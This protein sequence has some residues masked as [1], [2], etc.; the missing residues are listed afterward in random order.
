M[1]YHACK[2]DW[3]WSIM[4]EYPVRVIDGH[5]YHRADITGTDETGEV[6]RR[7]TA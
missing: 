7:V 1:K 5:E 2:V 6:Y 4:I 3:Y